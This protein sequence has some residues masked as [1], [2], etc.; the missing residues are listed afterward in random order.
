MQNY[1]VI[2]IKRGFFVSIFKMCY[3]EL[4]KKYSVIQAELCNDGFEMF[5][6]WTHIVW[7]N[8]LYV[9]VPTWH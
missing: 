6:V 5:N 9:C 3:D 8:V 2:I 4:L 1:W 7:I